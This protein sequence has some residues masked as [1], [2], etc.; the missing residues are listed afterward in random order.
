MNT[1]RKISHNCR[2]RQ[3]N[4]CMDAINFVM[5]MKQL[6][7]FKNKTNWEKLYELN[8]GK[9]F[10]FIHVRFVKNCS[11]FIYLY[12]KFNISLYIRVSLLSFHLS[13]FNLHSD[14][15]LC[16]NIMKR[17]KCLLKKILFLINVRTF[18][19]EFVIYF[20][21]LSF[22]IVYIKLS[23]FWEFIMSF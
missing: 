15:Y 20:F 13:H 17:K 14:I 1:V 5:K 16:I 21:F 11:S 4:I 7:Y 23:T 18:S 9:N 19:E 10:L 2:K 12:D 6:N 22:L 3:K 8:R